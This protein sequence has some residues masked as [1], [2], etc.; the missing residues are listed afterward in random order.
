MNP[1]SGAQ[2]FKGTIFYVWKGNR[3]CRIYVADGQVYFIRRAGSAISPG[4]AAVIGSQFGLVGGL[5]VGLANAKAR[6][7]ADL[8]Q[9]NDLTP[10]D[11][12]MSK[13]ADNYAIPVSE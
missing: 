5:A 7:P 11:H 1:T 13:H 8:V 12:L 3:P 9:D 6:K 4:A 2:S 10:P